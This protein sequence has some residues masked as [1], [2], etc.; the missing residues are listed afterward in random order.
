[1]IQIWKSLKRKLLVVK[2]QDEVV[3]L[4]I[5]V[6]NYV[7]ALQ[8]AGAAEKAHKQNDQDAFNV[9]AFWHSLEFTRPLR[10]EK[11]SS[12]LLKYKQSSPWQSRMMCYTLRENYI[13]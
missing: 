10:N 2:H 9:F 7:T 3:T 1:M 11:A 8:W 5:N 6:W 13:I 4:F 12:S